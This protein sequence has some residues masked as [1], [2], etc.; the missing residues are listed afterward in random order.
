MASAATDEVREIVDDALPGVRDSDDEEDDE[1]NEST[2]CLTA[3]L[4]LFA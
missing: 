3:S 1:D 2:V 4:S